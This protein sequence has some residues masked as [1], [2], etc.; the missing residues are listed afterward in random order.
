MFD[1]IPNK[2]LTLKSLPSPSDNW[3]TILKFAVT[4]AGYDAA[5]AER[6]HEEAKHCLCGP[7]AGWRETA[8]LRL[9]SYDHDGG[10][11]EI[12]EPTK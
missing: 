2:D 12:A 5:V 11:Q 1:T 10:R 8:A 3:S 6:E 7:G 9:Q 4:F